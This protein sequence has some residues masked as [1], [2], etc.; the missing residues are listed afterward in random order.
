MDETYIKIKGQWYYLY[1]TVDK[2][3][4]TID[5]LLTEHRDTEAA[6]CFLKKAI[7]RHGVPKTITIDGSD[8]N[9]AAIK[10]Y[11]EEQGTN[12]IPAYGGRQSTIMQ[13]WAFSVSFN[14]GILLANPR[15]SLHCTVARLLLDSTK[16]NSKTCMAGV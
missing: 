3:G 5:F 7:R 14:G 10:R 9:E 2:Y 1:R 15:I 16:I 11:N 12:I 8:A 6:L 13:L 4:E